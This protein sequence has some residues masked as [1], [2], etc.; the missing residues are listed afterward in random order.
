MGP[1]MDFLY[2]EINVC[3]VH[4]LAGVERSAIVQLPARGVDDDRVGRLQI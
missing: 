3:D 1:K 4:T 2:G